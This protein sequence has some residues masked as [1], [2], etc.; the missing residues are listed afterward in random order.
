MLAKN[1]A[2]NLVIQFKNSILKT[3]YFLAKNISSGVFL[4]FL[5]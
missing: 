3:N 4:F 2:R 5:E 1:I